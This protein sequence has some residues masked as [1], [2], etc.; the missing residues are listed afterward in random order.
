MGQGGKLGYRPALDGLRATAVLLVILTHA[1]VPHFEQA[2]AVG[3]TVFFVLSGFLITRLLLDEHERTGRVNFRHFYA[4]RARRLLPALLAFLFLDGVVRAVSGQ[5]LVPV[6]LAAIYTSNIAPSAIGIMF[7]ELEHTWSLSLEEQFYLLWPATLML[8]VR[9]RYALPVLATGALASAALRIGLWSAGAG[10]ARVY[11]A[12]DT[13][14]DALLV[15]CLLGLTIHRLHRPGRLDATAAALALGASCTLGYVGILWALLPVSVCAAVLVAWS[16]D[17]YGWL[18]YRPL[19]FVGRISYGLY[20]WHY[21]VAL[22]VREK[23]GLAGLPITLAV[24]FA[25]AV[26]S[27]FV[28]ERRFRRRPARVTAASFAEVVAVAAEVHA[29][30]QEL[31]PRDLGAPGPSAK[32]IA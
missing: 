29:V 7:R 32:G 19:V 13:R 2:G 5:S 1:G 30:K 22:Y 31:A 8:L 17:H 11:I 27:W 16:L 21:P 4:K 10:V 24:S 25:L 20:L 12:P 14:A 18:A 15:G 6:A 3:V 23:F 26:A 9:T 28:I